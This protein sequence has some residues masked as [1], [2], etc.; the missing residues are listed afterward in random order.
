M[1]GAVLERFGDRR[2]I[3]VM[4]RGTL[5]RVLGADPLDLWYER[6]AQKQSTRALLCSTVYDLMRPVV[7]RI[8]PAV[9]AAYRAQ[10]A[11]VGTSVVSVYNKLQE[12]ETHTSA[13]LVR[14]SARKCAPL[15][16]HVGGERAPW[17]PGSQGKSVDGNAIE[18]REHRLQER[19]GGE[20]GALPGQSL[21]VSEPGSGLVRDV[22]PCEDG[23]AQE[24]SW[25]TAV[26]R[27]VPAGDRWIAER[28]FWTRKFLCDLD[29]RGAY[30][31]IRQHRG[32][33]F[34]IGSPLHPL[35]RVETGQS[36][37]HRVRVVDAQGGVHVGRRL[38]ITLNHPTRDG[39]TLL[40][41]LT[42]VPARPVSGKRVARC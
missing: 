19:R 9:H 23:H 29:A 26:L 32:W 6:T 12:L 14:D 27:T 39:A 17:L 10:E 8:Q 33:P 18:A 25:C 40:S 30:F 13:E 3:S 22:F 37:E 5:E 34:E 41:V 16:E 28:N 31:V 24:R 38:R 2:P 15:I 42:H 1:L 7:F 20:A 36:A 21:V 35:G 4:V 11:Q